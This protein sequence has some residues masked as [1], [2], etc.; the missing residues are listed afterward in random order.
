[1]YLTSVDQNYR[2]FYEK[3]SSP[4]NCLEIYDQG[5]K[6]EIQELFVRR[7][8]TVIWHS[9]RWIDSFVHW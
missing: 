1:M 3:I 7:N 4:K 5:K 8:L 9:D 2:R 6:D